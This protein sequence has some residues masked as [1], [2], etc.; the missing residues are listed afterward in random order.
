[1]LSHPQASLHSLEWD[2]ALVGGSPAARADA[3]A[4]GQRTRLELHAAL[5][6][7]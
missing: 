7:G 5:D 1:L 6:L 2:R 3:E 4:A